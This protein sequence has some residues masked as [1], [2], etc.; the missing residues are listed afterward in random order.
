MICQKYYSPRRR[1]VKGSLSCFILLPPAM[2][3][4][5]VSLRPLD[6]MSS[7]V[8][9]FFLVWCA[10]LAPGASAAHR[11]GVVVEGTTRGPGFTREEGKRK[12]LL[13][14]IFFIFFKKNFYVVSTTCPSS[15]PHPYQGG[16]R[17]CSSPWKFVGGGE[18]CDGTH[19]KV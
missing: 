2:P 6:M 4:P 5:Y 1:P 10:H 8:T 3:G 12:G 7:G 15:H 19:L 13:K 14:I 17:C 18:G 9:L 11:S 16:R